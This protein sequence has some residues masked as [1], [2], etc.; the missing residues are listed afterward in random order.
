MRGFVKTT[1]LVIAALALAACASTPSLRKPIERERVYSS[2]FEK[3]WG[4]AIT[5]LARSGAM[6]NTTDKGAGL[7]TYTRILSRD[8]LRNFTSPDEL[9][10]PFGAGR[11]TQGLG[12]M[13]LLIKPLED[14]KSQVFINGRI[15]VRST[16][17]TI[18]GEAAQF[19][20]FATSNGKMEEEFLDQLALELGEK[21]FPWLKK[22][23]K[24]QEKK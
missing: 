22:D 3:V 11:F 1:V 5:N 19:T 15:Q 7:I 18:R 9:S 23:A 20:H 12:Y 21:E 14:G 16:L 8:E 17:F 24:P 13:S 4:A 6:I 10:G 2:S